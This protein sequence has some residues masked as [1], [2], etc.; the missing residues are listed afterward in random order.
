MA[1]GT[2]TRTPEPGCPRR[3]SPLARRILAVNMLALAILVGGAMVLGR[4]QDRLIRSDLEALYTEAR[5]FAGALAEAA[6]ARDADGRLVLEADLARRL[7]RRLG[8][9]TEARTR[10]YDAAG[11]LVADSQVATAGGGGPPREPE[12]EELPPAS[13]WLLHDLERLYAAFAGT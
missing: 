7:V 12:T 11:Q 5:I 4:Y 2:G 1:S 6:V 3:L 10:L 8:E 9:P 13:R